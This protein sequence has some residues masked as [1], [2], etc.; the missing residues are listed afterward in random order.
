MRRGHGATHDGAVLSSLAP[1][2]RRLV[3]AVG[4][5][6][7]V[8]VAVLAAFVVA[9]V[10]S[11]DGA[12]R[13]VDQTEPG[14]VLLVPGYGGSTATLEPLAVSLRAA[15][16]D[17]TVVE[18]PGRAL[19]DLQG[20]ADALAAAATR[21]LDRT[22]ADSVDLVGYSAGG[23]VA[24]LWVQEGDGATSV[25]RFVTL[26]SPHHGTQLASL[27]ALV[28]GACPVACQQLAPQSPV[29]AR[30]DSAPLPTGPRYLAL[31]T[32]Q[33]D[34]V[35]PAVSGELDGAQSVSVQDVCPDDRVRHSGLPADEVVQGLVAG[36]LGAGAIP[37][38]GPGDCA[39]LSS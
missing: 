21:V 29:L 27:G 4:G 7:V 35:V 26:G 38:W 18:L 28:S 36:S 10:I 23:I 25:R 19:G 39:R 11:G 15:G 1:A 8:A 20:Q 30:L 16:R 37:A 22:G 6:L 17:V 34:V 31:W 9:G 13:P 24:R 5:F 32:T 2:R 33:D 12:T 3:L 14:P